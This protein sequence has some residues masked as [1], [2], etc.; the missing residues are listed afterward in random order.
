MSNS[1]P[2]HSENPQN[3]ARAGNDLDWNLVLA[4]AGHEAAASAQNTASTSEANRAS[5]SDPK[6]YCELC[7]QWY[8]DAMI[9]I[10]RD[11][12][13][14]C[15]YC[16]SEKL[17]LCQARIDERFAN[18]YLPYAKKA[19]II[20]V[21]LLA[22]SLLKWGLPW[23]KKSAPPKTT[24]ED[25]GN[26]HLLFVVGEDDDR[27]VGLASKIFIT[28][29][30]PS[31]ETVKLMVAVGPQMKESFAEASRFLRKLP[32]DWNRSYSIRLSFEDKFS[33]KDGGSAGAGFTV[34]MLSAV[35]R[36][37][38]D[39]YIA[40]TGGVSVDGE[41]EPVGAIPEKLRGAV[42]EKCKLSIIPNRNV[43]DAEDL[44]L[45]DGIEPF[46]NTQVFSA[47]TINDAVSLA[48]ADREKRTEEAIERFAALRKRL[49]EDATAEDLKQ[50]PFRIELM[51]ILALAPNHV[52]ARILLAAADGALPEKLSLVRSLEEVMRTFYLFTSYAFEKEQRRHQSSV[53]L[54]GFPEREYA[55]AMQRMIA[56]T[57][58][59]DTRVL[60][61]RDASI[62]FAKALKPVWNASNGTSNMMNLHL[63]GNKL[64]EQAKDHL[65]LSLRR[66]DS[67]GSLIREI[68]KK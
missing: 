39:P 57:P 19:I 8:P 66:V 16:A 52:S 44:A 48:R 60:E 37:P 63:A 54:G 58:I 34:G 21:L 49:P 3:Q 9:G 45:L 4:D 55:D 33:Q 27:P 5:A 7:A 65:L 18:P 11:K 53:E 67:D 42:D 62:E 2:P 51:E 43:S 24:V 6:V 31:P 40:I 22:A 35:Q 15:R 17:S 68:L 50:M 59:L 32:E 61:T 46:C 38:L 56:L 26:L 23:S 47:E 14:F 28:R 41:V 36:F 20:A 10:R 13:N 25:V 1:T 64:L 30:P 29:E 12:L